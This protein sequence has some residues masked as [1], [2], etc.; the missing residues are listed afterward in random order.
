[1]QIPKGFSLIPRTDNYVY[2]EQSDRIYNMKTGRELQPADSGR[3]GALRTKITAKD[4]S[5]FWCVHDDIGKPEP[6]DLTR[7]QVLQDARIIPDYPRYAVTRG[8]QIFCIEPRIMGRKPKRIHIVDTHEHQGW[9]HASLT[10]S[11]GKTRKVR[12]NK[13]VSKVWG[14]FDT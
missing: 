4:G 11:D 3:V 10:C 6:P 13:V 9:E 8:G 2:S 14:K 5:K 1:M 7:E 12:V